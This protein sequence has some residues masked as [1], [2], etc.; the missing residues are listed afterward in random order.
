MKKIV[1]ILLCFVLGSV[2]FTS[3]SNSESPFTQ[4][5]YTADAEQIKKV[6]IDVQDR[7]IEVSVS[8]DNQIHIDYFENAKEH[9]EISVS[10][11][12][13]LTMTTVNDKSWED[14]IGG[15]PSAEHRRIALQIPDALLGALTLSTTNEDI[16][17]PPLAIT[18]DVSLSTNGGNIHFDR[19]NAGKSIALRSKNGDISGAIVGSYEDY[20]ITCDI[21]KGE[22]NLPSQKENGAKTLQVSNNNGDVSITFTNQAQ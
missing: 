7:L 10:P 3:C 11:D 12:Q 9:Y 18:D 4:E 15:K 19:L 17:L 14:Y 2:L 1:S 20:A 6:Q 21:K 16:S 13:V 8:E 22:S 5:S